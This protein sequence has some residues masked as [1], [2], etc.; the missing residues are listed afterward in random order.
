MRLCM[1]RIGVIEATEQRKPATTRLR[2]ALLRSR[3]A[4]RMRSLAIPPTRLPITPAK[5][6]PAENSAEFFRSSL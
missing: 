4:T 5:N 3:V 2:R 1:K 6:T